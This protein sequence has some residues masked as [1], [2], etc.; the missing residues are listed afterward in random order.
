MNVSF[1]DGPLVVLHVVAFVAGMVVVGRTV[2]S[3]IRNFIMPRADPLV[4]SRFVF[5]VVRHVFNVR[6]SRTK[7]YLD[8]DRIMAIYAPMSLVLLAVTW[9]ALVGAGYTA[10]FWA[11]GVHPIRDAAIASGSSMFTLGFVRPDG[12]P[13]NVL[14]F[15]EA[16]LGLGLVALLIS[17]LPSIY[18][19]FTRR[20]IVVSMLEPLAG[21]PATPTALLVRHHLVGGLDR[22]EDVW[23]RWRVWF[24]DIEESHTSIS[25]IVFFR[26]PHP[27]Q[28]WITAAGC[29]LDSA[30]LASSCLDLPRSS[31]SAFCIRAGYVSLRRIATF[32]AIPYPI[33]PEPDDPISVTRA[34]FDEVWAS[35]EARGVPLKSDQDQ[36]WREFAGWRVNYDEVLLRLC[37]LTMAPPARWSGD[38]APAFTAPPFWGRRKARRAQ[39]A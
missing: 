9:V 14:A 32:F 18:A 4:L 26:S 29:V 1:G 24:A 6:V 7:A 21:S 30:A 38:R 3:A 16:G 25:A 17:Y 10:M 28:S 8:R 5:L 33:D 31:N 34:E 35:L 22:L 36:A 19:A 37:A 23:D 12:V 11:V 39:P 15:T 20:E 2:M 13:Q 27:D